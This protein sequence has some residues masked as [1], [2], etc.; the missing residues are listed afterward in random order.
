MTLPSEV[1]QGTFIETVT[2]CHFPIPQSSSKKKIE[3]LVRILQDSGCQ[4]MEEK[5]VL[6][7]VLLVI[8]ES[9]Q[10]MQEDQGLRDSVGYTENS[11]SV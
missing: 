3:P 9:G 10:W 8:S 5:M 2:I 7:I 1:S 11:S 4:E 6:G